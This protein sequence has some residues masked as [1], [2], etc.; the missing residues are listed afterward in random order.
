VPQIH[1][2][3]RLEALFVLFPWICFSSQISFY[4]IALYHRFIF[5]S[6]EKERLLVFTYGRPFSLG[7][8]S[9]PHCAGFSEAMIVAQALL[10]DGGAMLFSD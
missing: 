1:C 5:F 7:L 6:N 2:F 8:F 10:L 4:I 3:R 9:Q